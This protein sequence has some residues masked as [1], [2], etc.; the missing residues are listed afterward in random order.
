MRWKTIF[1]DLDSAITRM[2]TLATS[3]QISG[4]VVNV[5]VNSLKYAQPE[6]CGDSSFEVLKS[7]LSEEQLAEIDLFD[8]SGVAKIVE[9]CKECWSMPDAGRR[10][11]AVSRRAKTQPSDFDSVK[12]SLGRFGLSWRD[13]HP[14]L[15]Q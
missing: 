6:I 8:Q 4:D 7:V 5:E 9:V 1:F 3:G 14:E 15:R 11:F 12:K 13:I 2:V 10:L